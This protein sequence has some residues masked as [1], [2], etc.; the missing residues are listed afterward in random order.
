MLY[1]QRKAN[2]IGKINNELKDFITDGCV[3]VV[4]QCSLMMEAASTSAAS[5]NLHHTALRDNQNRASFILAVVR[6]SNLAMNA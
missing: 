2:E 5:V 6:T 4:E 3:L 1:I